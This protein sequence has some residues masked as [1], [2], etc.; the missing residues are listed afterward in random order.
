MYNSLSE[1]ITNPDACLDN[2]E[3]TASTN[4]IISLRH[5]IV[6]CCSSKMQ[7]LPSQPNNFVGSYILVVVRRIYPRNISFSVYSHKF[8]VEVIIV[9]FQS[10]HGELRQLIA[11]S[12][13]FSMVHKKAIFRQPLF[14]ARFLVSHSVLV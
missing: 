2:Y 14:L 11:S 10:F 8:L 3:D 5:R 13:S 7:I 12:L 1:D 9:K 6:F 4:E